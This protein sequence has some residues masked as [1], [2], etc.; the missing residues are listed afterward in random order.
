MK[1]FII[2]LILP[3][4]AAM[5]S[6]LVVY[7]KPTPATQARRWLILSMICGAACAM[8]LAH[9]Y[10]PTLRTS[11]ILDLTYDAV[12]LCLAPCFYLCLQSLTSIEGIQKQDYLAFVPGAI[13]MSIILALNLIMGAD[14]A[15][16]ALEE[17]VLRTRPA[18]EGHSWAYRVYTFFG[19]TFY[20]S[21]VI[22]ELIAVFYYGVVA[23][24]RYRKQLEDY[25]VDIPP[26]MTTGIV[27]LHV[28]FVLF[29]LVG[30]VFAAC[31][32]AQTQ[33]SWVV[34]TLSV[35]TGLS[36][37]M[38][39][40]FAMTITQT[41]TITQTITQTETQTITQTRSV[42]ET[43]MQ[44]GEEDPFRERLAVIEKENLYRDPN[45][46]IFTLSRTIGTNR[47]YLARAFKE[48]YGETFSE[49]INRLRVEE[50]V[51]LMREEK[52]LTLGEI[53]ERVGYNSETSLYRNFVRRYH[54]APSEV[55]EKCCS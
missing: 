35:G 11:I 52:K 8:L 14:E 25:L 21:F 44:T 16:A 31:E 42:T 37:L 48:C 1:H 23:I 15:Q 3:M 40:Y 29:G 17:I 27:M 13:L 7:L 34:P 20:R 41:Q 9:Y 50:A 36:F 6:A 30:M 51:R 4:A 38:M 53:A 45:L 46:T 55:R 19:H 2:Y 54:C 18:T 28:S 39:G 47:T 22:I 10:H 43:I 24:R 26:S 5:V 32:Y 49:H 12:M 33:N